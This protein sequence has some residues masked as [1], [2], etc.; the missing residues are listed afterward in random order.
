M[1]DEAKQEEHVVYYCL[2]QEDE[3]RW[4]VLEAIGDTGCEVTIIGEL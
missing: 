1:R 3:E 4:E 2:E